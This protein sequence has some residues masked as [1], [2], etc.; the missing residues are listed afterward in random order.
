M[1]ICDFTV[2]ELNR[3]RELCNF[4]DDEMTYFNM[5][6]KN[7]SNVQIAYEMNVSESTVSVLARKVKK[8][9]VRVL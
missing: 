5:R 9:I 3:F 8:K 6:S 4:T 1:K 7:K 2:P